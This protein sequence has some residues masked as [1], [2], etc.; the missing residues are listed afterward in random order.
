VA[1]NR[2]APSV[3]V[4]FP[5]QDDA[6]QDVDR[7]SFIRVVCQYGSNNSAACWSAWWWTKVGMEQDEV[8]MLMQMV[9]RGPNK[10]IVRGVTEQ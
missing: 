8:K 3:D 10:Y 2:Q 6:P 5:S 4:V 9:Y 1:F 7:D